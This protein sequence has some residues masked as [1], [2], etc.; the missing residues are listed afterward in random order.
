MTDENNTLI[1]VAQDQNAL[2][3][4]NSEEY[5]SRLKLCQGGAKEVNQKK[6]A[7]GGNYA[8]IHSKD[9][10]DD[11]G[12]DVEIILAASR[13][14]AL[15]TGEKILQYFDPDSAEFKDIEAE[16]AIKDSGCMYGPE[17][18]IWIPAQQKFVTLFLCNPTGRRASKSFF[19]AMGKG[20]ILGSILIDNG[21]YQWF[22][23]TIEESSTP[24][25]DIPD[26]ETLTSAVEKFMNERPS[27]VK[28]ADPATGGRAV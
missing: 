3:V 21:D 17:F 20:A 10:I 16:A 19:K 12:T 11:A 26:A 28:K 5:L 13:A 18:L 23:P 14:K 1:P 27:A 9:K 2:K 6:V 22:G 7:C 15:R 4:S 25:E 24:I 8:L